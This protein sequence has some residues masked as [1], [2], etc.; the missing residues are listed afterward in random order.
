LIV[1]SRKGLPATGNNDF[2]LLAVNG[3]ILVLSPAASINAFKVGTSPY[4]FCTEINYML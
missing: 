1:C 3:R 4:S 2:G